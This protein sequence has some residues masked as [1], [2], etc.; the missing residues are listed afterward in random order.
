MSSATVPARRSIVVSVVAA[1]LLGAAVV[2]LSIP[3][4]GGD[5]AAHAAS[6]LVAGLP[7]LLLLVSAR[8]WPPPASRLGRRL[9][10][11]GM[12]VFAAGQFLEVAGAFGYDGYAR[13]NALAILHDAGLFGVVGLPVLLSG[14]AVLV[15]AHVRNASLLRWKR[16]LTGLVF[17]AFVTAIAWVV[18]GADF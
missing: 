7:L 17:V 6:H 3:V 10:L 16:A 12:A 9:L 18:L 1:L 4:R 15:V 2:V 8:R 11:A 13:V 5:E 14:L